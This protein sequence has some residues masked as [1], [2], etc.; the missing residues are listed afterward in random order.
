MAKRS[1]RKKQEQKQY[2]I[3]SIILLIL[4]SFF[5]IVNISAQNSQSVSELPLEISI[6]EAYTYRED[7]AFILDVR[8][9]EE[10]D[11]FHIP[12]ATLI[13]LDE[14]PNRL[15]E[16]PENLEIVVVCNSGNRSQ[17]A[18]DILLSAGFASV[19]SMDGGVSGWQALGY[20]IE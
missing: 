12:G 5:V 6:Q 20:P 3:G 11:S 2:I 14:L 10:W 15:E 7:G 18:R 19:T 4:V 8:T 16:V 9:Q 1:R 13:P 17:Q